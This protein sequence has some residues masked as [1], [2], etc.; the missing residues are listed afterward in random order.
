MYDCFIYLW[1]WFIMDAIVL[2]IFITL[3]VLLAILVW[4]AIKNCETINKNN[5]L[6]EDEKE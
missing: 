2:S 5:E 3:G 1:T 6:V 4:L